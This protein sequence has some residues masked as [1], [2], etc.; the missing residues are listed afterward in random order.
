LQEVN[1][2]IERKLRDINAA[3][4]NPLDDDR[5]AL[6]LDFEINRQLFF[7]SHIGL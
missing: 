1:H 5:R 2:T 6:N 7:A 4:H 3:F